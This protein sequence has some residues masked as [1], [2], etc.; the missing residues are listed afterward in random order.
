VV[1]TDVTPDDSFG[2]RCA[3]SEAWSG[4]S[5]NEPLITAELALDVFK[6]RGPTA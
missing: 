3:G 2:W 4:S 1:P 5:Y 6:V